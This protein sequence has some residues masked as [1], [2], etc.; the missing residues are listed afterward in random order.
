MRFLA[1]ILALLF[2]ILSAQ[3]Q[4]NWVSEASLV[5]AKEGAELWASPVYE[6]GAL[7]GR[8]Y[9]AANRKAHPIMVSVW[10]LDARNVVDDLPHHWIEV[11]PTRHE[12]ERTYLGRI[13]SRTSHHLPPYKIYWRVE[14]VLDDLQHPYP[15]RS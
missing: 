11:Q 6:R 2:G 5:G 1:S 12:E 4:P 15:R 7:V 3:P 10:L 14:A 13:T 9:W 8:D